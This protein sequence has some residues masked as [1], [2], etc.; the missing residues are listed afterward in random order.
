MT[1]GTII[2][3]GLSTDQLMQMIATVV[4]QQ[5]EQAIRKTKEEDLSERFYSINETRKLF[6]PALSRQTIYNWSES[7]KLKKHI[8]S[9]RVYYKYSEI[10]QAVKHLKKY[11]NKGLY[12]PV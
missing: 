8:I 11:S 5:V 2:L 4:S 9:G 1:E 7:G 3:N 10:M 12:N 6:V